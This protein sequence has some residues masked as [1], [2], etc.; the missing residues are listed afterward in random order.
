MSVDTEARARQISYERP[1]LYPKQ[2]AAFFTGARYSY[3]EASTKAG[4]THSCI[5]WIVELAVLHGFKGWNGWWVAPTGAQA[6]I[7]YRRIKN[8]VPS[9][10]IHWNDSE[11]WI[12]FINGA[13][14]WFK[15]A[16]KPDNLY[17][18]DVYAAVYDEA[19]RGRYDSFVALRSTL[20]ATRG[21]IRLIGNVKGKS[22][23][24]YLQCRATERKQ[25]DKDYDGNAE[26]HRITA[27]DAVEAG[28]LEAEEIEDAKAALPEN[29]FMELY[30][31][32]AADDEEAFIP[33]KYIELAI[34]RG[35]KKLVQ[36]SGK[37]VI[38]ADPSQGK[39]DSAAFALRTG[40]VVEEVQEHAGM[41]EFGFIAHICRLVEVRNPAAVFIDGTGFGTTIVKAIHERGEVF[42]RIVKGFHMAE[43]P[44]LVD[45]YTNKRAECW[46]EM[47][48][49]LIS[50]TEPPSLPDDDGLSIELGVLR[51]V[52]TSSGKLQ[53]EG[54]SELKTRGYDSPNK[55]DALSLTFAEPV[56]FYINEK[57]N[58]PQAR[59]NRVIS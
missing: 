16:E 10:F 45:E 35:R 25:A 37:L 57:I 24:F 43:R 46:G 31:A 7:A 40:A 2:E 18:E 33:S 6:K 1:Y 47:R 48:K 5:V 39:G 27:Y 51:T 28:V 14:I 53:L 4:K 8:S 58:Y 12:E 41:D 59:R 32:V 26:F 52:P 23:W 17:G 30:L 15:T 3:V 36:P 49:W 56:S 44:T 9:A 13:R 20:T 19:S 34:D 11:A 38:G 55:A 42:R 50:N 21:A 29:E 22:N 54:K